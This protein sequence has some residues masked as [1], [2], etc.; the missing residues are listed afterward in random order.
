MSLEWSDS[1][2]TINWHELQNLFRL[3]PLGDKSA[4]LLQTVFTI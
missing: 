3:A 4:E 1:Q 2:D